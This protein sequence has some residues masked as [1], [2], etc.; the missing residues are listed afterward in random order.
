[1]QYE[2]IPFSKKVARV[3]FPFKAVQLS[4]QSEILQIIG[5]AHEL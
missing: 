2:Y 3:K 4:V 5:P 1:M